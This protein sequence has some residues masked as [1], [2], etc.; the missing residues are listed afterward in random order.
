M[1]PTTPNPILTTSHLATWTFPVWELK[2]E[3]EFIFCSALAFLLVSAVFGLDVMLLHLARRHIKSQPKPGRTM[4]PNP[5]P[6]PDMPRPQVA[7]VH[8]GPVGRLVSTIT[9]MYESYQRRN[10]N[11]QN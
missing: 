2:I 3:S 7:P 10:D 1:N 11:A 5:A 6:T 4:R 9:R 8:I